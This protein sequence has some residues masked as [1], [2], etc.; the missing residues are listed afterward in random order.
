MALFSAASKLSRS[1]LGG[2]GAKLVIAQ[3]PDAR[4][5]HGQ[6]QRLTNRLI[7][8][9]YN[10]RFAR[11]ALGQLL[12]GI[13]TNEIKRQLIMIGNGNEPLPAIA[14]VNNAAAL[15]YPLCPGRAA[16]GNAEKVIRRAGTGDT[17]GQKGGFMRC[18]TQKIAVK[19]HINVI[20][21]SS[22]RLE[23][24]FAPSFVFAK[25]ISTV[26]ICFSYGGFRCRFF[27]LAARRS[28]PVCILS[29]VIV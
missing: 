4:F 15:T 24:S 27:C 13:R 5:R 12:G 28:P 19:Q 1:A 10:G 25:K 26:S 20:A 22:G 14:A 6:Q 7:G 8:F 21:A 23:G 16:L 17:R 3:L 2:Y 11:K 29:L 18:K 9:I